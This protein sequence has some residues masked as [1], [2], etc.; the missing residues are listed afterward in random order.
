MAYKKHN[1]VDGQVLF[2]KDLNEMD[3]QIKKYERSIANL[4][5]AAE[6]KL[7]RE[8]VDSTEAYRKD[9]ANDVLPFASLDMIGGKSVVWNQI[10]KYPTNGNYSNKGLN[11]SVS[12][13]A[14]TLNGTTTSQVTISFNTTVHRKSGHV[15]YLC[16]CPA[17]GSSSSYY[18]CLTGVVSLQNGDY[19]FDFG[20]GAICSAI[21]DVSENTMDV[22]VESGVTVNNVIFKPK[23]IDLTVLYGAGNEPT[24]TDDERIKF[25]EAYAEA[26]P[27]YNEGEIISADVDSVVS[28]G[29]NLW[30]EQWRNG[31][32]NRSGAFLQA[33]DCICSKNPINVLP[34]TTYYFTGDV[35]NY[36]IYDDTDNVVRFSDVRKFTTPYNAK[37]MHFYINSSY[38]NVYKNDI[39]ICKSTIERDGVYTPY[40]EPITTEIPSSIRNIEGYGWS[41]GSVYNEVDFVNK[42]FIKRVG[43]V[44]MGTLDWQGNN[45]SNDGKGYVHF[46][47][48]LNT[49]IGIS[50]SLYNVI[51]KFSYNLQSAQ[52]ENISV[53]DYFIAPSF[54]LVYCDTNQSVSACKKSLQGVMM[55][56]EL[57]EPEI[58]DIADVF[59]NSIEV[60][61]GGT[62]TFHQPDSKCLPIPNQETFVV[63]VGDA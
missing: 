19:R 18:F 1:F 16:G 17:G 52:W 4:E 45:A 61:A 44:D 14:V 50:K 27:E 49:A 30:D 25:I 20:Q 8:D 36:V 28:N 31:F 10:A 38:G 29:R 40:R 7:Y 32:Y 26:H 55:Y 46:V 42:K 58:I 41:A 39:C 62:I 2:A 34:N 24:T 13:F 35:N 51:T 60:E 33:T 37:Y 43:A 63:K 6:G 54:Y 21:S 5:A 59:D 22:V 48:G 11:Y 57:A 47:G 53:G 15:Y 23:C 12:N 3:L 56:Y 9:I